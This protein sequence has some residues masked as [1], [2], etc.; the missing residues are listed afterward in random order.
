MSCSWRGIIAAQVAFAVERT[1]AEDEGAPER[2]APAVCARSRGDGHVGLGPRDPDRSLVRQPRARC[3]G[4]RPA[5]S[6][7]RSR[8]TSERFI[9]TT[10]RA[11]SPRSA[12]PSRTACRTR[13]STASSRPTASVR[14]VEGKGRVEHEDGRPV[15]MAGV[16]MMV[17][18]RKEAELARLGVRRRGEPAEGRVSRDAVARA[19]DAAQRH[20]R[21]GAGARRP[22]GCRRS[23]CG[24]P[25]RSSAAT[26]GCRRS[27][28]KTFS[29]C[30]ASSPASS[31]STASPSCVDQLLETAIERCRAGG[32]EQ[33]GFTSPAR[34]PAD[35]PPIEG[36]PK[37]LQ[38][39]FGNVLSN[40]IKF[41]PEGG[42]VAWCAAA[43]AAASRSRFTTPA[44]ASR[45]SFCPT[46]STGS[47]RPIAG[48]RGSTAGLG[49]GLA[50]A[51]HLVEQHGGRDSGA[52]RGARPR[53][54][55][56][57]ATAG[58]PREPDLMSIPRER[59]RRAVDVA[60]HRQ[61]QLRA[62]AGRE[63]HA[64]VARVERRVRPFH[65]TDSNWCSA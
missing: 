3:M 60:P 48:R 2:R 22:T 7:A 12:A 11:C 43:R 27:S 64:E 30:R 35:L 15:R 56:C 36:D 31:R 34:S 54:E 55:R 24:T 29:T 21:L 39:V 16:C 61:R 23:G 19:A 1:R 52:E 38:Q 46:S 53:D 62:R 25:S 17:T 10:A 8:A 50:L 9:P 26:P 13:S 49:L 4:S 65:S 6:T 14:W 28:S 45:P 42:R 33:A 32:R 57:D 58:E 59:H 40:A 37:R 20:P 51:R 63:L 5:P 44:S 41:T 47:A 18:R